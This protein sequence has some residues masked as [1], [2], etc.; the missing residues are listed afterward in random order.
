ME[1]LN[2]KL[3]QEYREYQCTVSK[4]WIYIEH[5]RTSWTS[6]SSKQMVHQTAEDRRDIK[7]LRIGRKARSWGQAGHQEDEDKRDIKKLRTGGTSKSWGQAGHQEAEDR[8]DIK[9]LR[10]GGKRIKLHRSVGKYYSGA[11]WALEDTRHAAEIQTQ[12]HRLQTE[13]GP[14]DSILKKL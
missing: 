6:S 9:K 7:K 4:V 1:T 2:I 12:L 13:C 8:R 14:E 3:I 11:A 5:Q 10:T